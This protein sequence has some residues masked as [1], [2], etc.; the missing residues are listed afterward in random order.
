[1]GSI[2]AAE[3]WQI[4]A[5]ESGFFHYDS[6]MVF[7]PEADGYVKSLIFKAPANRPSQSPIAIAACRTV[8]LVPGRPAQLVFR[9]RD[10]YA[11]RE[12]RGYYQLYIR[13]NERDLWRVDAADDN[14]QLYRVEIPAECLSAGRLPVE[15]GLAGV[16]NVQNY[17]LNARFDSIGIV[18]DGK[19]LPLQEVVAASPSYAPIPD[20]PAVPAAPPR[21]PEWFRNMVTVQAWF[22]SD[23]NLQKR[24]D[25]YLPLVADELRMNAIC[26]RVPEVFNAMHHN[27]K[28]APGHSNLPPDEFMVTEEEFREALAAYRAAG[29]KI[30][31]YTGII[32][33]GHDE[34]WNDGTLQRRHPEWLQCGANGE[35]VKSFGNENFCPNTGALDF[36]IEYSKKIQEKYGAD[37]LMFDNNFFQIP[38]GGRSESCHCESC[39]AKFKAYVL[40]H[41]GDVLE[42]AFGITPDEVKIPTRQGPFKMLW[43]DWR[44][45]CWAEAME[46]VRAAIDVPVFANTEFMW[47]DWQLGVDRMYRHEDAVFSESN[48]LG[49]LPEKYC[50]GNAFA[51]DRPHFSYLVT[52]VVAGERYWQMRA[53][54]D[55]AELLGTTMVYNIN[56]W[57]M[58]HGWDPTLGYPE[59]IGDANRPSQEIIRKYFQFHDRY[60]AWFRE[61]TPIH[62]T[63]VVTS[64]RNRMANAGMNFSLGLSRMIRNGFAVDAIHDLTLADTDLSCFAF[65]VADRYEYMSDAEAE[66]LNEYIRNGGRV[67][68]SPDSGRRDQF[69]RVRPAGALEGA[70]VYDDVTAFTE[71][72]LAEKSAVWRSRCYMTVVKPYRLPDGTVLLQAVVQNKKHMVRDFELPVALHGAK[73]VVLHTPHRSE[74]VPLAVKNHVVS[75]PEDVWYFILEVKQP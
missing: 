9:Y 67:Y 18:Q 37:A 54:A 57:L 45:R 36:A 12:N 5:D 34:K 38:E 69:G 44:N 42:S 55:V 21:I 73:Q 26:L 17:V 58:F 64:S 56:L 14:D 39:Q 6:D 40:E 29:F 41:Y 46:K 2:V 61:M 48:Y 50:L 3:N 24:R 7:S 70:I 19:Y 71:K 52:F 1:M 43:I 8:E 75:I 16:R 63:G 51:P 30:I 68:A 23:Y 62:E 47:R 11:A 22:Q 28:V 60:A 49:N 31:L 74:P 32:H 72:L 10:G 35:T 65:I 59:P 20:T 15:I 25:V 27:R 4:R 13:S 66:N 53:P 33:V